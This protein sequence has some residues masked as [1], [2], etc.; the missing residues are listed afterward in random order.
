MQRVL[1][2]VAALLTAAAA[3]AEGAFDPPRLMDTHEVR[4]LIE[5]ADATPYEDADRLVLFDRSTIEVED[6][7]LSHRYVHRLVKVLEPGGARALRALRFDF[8]PASNDVQILGLRIHRAGSTTVDIDPAKARDTT[9]PASMIYWGARMKV[10]GLPPLEP[11]DAV[12]SLSYTKGFL[13]AYLAGDEERFIPPMRG[14]FYD[15]IT[16]QDDLPCLEKRYELHLPKDKPLQYSVYNGE[17]ASSLRFGEEHL[18]YSFWRTAMPAVKREPRMP[19]LTDLVPKVVMATAEDWE[20]KSRWFYETNEWVFESNPEIDEKVREITRGLSE[21]EAIA[22]L[23]HWVAQG[24][25]YS[26][27]SMGEGE[28]YT[29]HPSSMTF[30]DR[31]GVCKDIAG[32]LVTM[33]RVA[34]FETYAAMTMAGARV[35]E[36]PADQ[37]NHCVVALRKSDGEYLMLDPT[38]A[39]WN[40]PLWSRWEGEQNYVIGTPWGEDRMAIRAF[41]PAESEMS[42]RSRAELFADGSLVGQFMLKG[43]G[44]ADG[45]LR[46]ARADHRADEVRRVFEGW[47]RRLSPRAEL[48]DYRL[49]DHRDFTRD[50]ELTL[51]YRVPRYADDLGDALKLRSPGLA[52]AADFGAL[53][54]LAGAPDVEDREHPLFMWGPQT[55]SL[56][57]EVALPRKMK[58]EAPSD[59]ESPGQA[60][61]ASLDWEL[62]GRTLSLSAAGTLGSRL[63]DPEDWPEV[64]DAKRT[65]K[66]GEETEILVRKEGGER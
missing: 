9:A 8:D 63:V 35:E 3:L 20:A 42:I 54:R 29:I 13:I 44:V 53:N 5:G 14:H 27:L 4:A 18:I 45:T 26:G 65:L 28:G 22:A 46:G 21:D 43:K 41:D 38:W 19:D 32:M 56:D 7:G 59:E 15:V 12:E 24:I 55:M 33:L 62:D 1:L 10:L 48:T 25:R 34:G 31:C 6:S 58:A 16:F 2:I 11:G 50:T 52:L 47:V 36:V 17:V 40:N 39:P 60:A 66:K 61:S 64:R 49:S 37:F 51:A 57:E 30:A 23:L